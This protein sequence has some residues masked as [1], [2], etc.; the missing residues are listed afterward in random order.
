MWRLVTWSLWL[1][2]VDSIEISVAPDGSRQ[3]QFS[4][5]QREVMTSSLRPTQLLA[6]YINTDEQ[7]ERRKHMERQAR[8]ANLPLLRFPAINRER[9]NLG[10]F[11]KKY[12]L[13]Q[14][15]SSELLDPVR[16]KDHVVNATVACYV[17][18]NELLETFQR[19]LQPNQIGLVLEDDVEIPHNWAELIDN[20]LSCAPNDWALLKVSGWGYS[21]E[22]DLQDKPSETDVTNSSGLALLSWL[23]SQGGWMSRILYGAPARKGSIRRNITQRHEL[24]QIANKEFSD[25]EDREDMIRVLKKLLDHDSPGVPEP[26]SN[27]DHDGACP[28]AYLM[29][30]PFKETFWWHFWG[31]AF[32]YAGT[33]AYLVKASSIPSVLSHLRS[34]PINDID[35]MLLS[36]GDLRAYELWPHIFPLDGDH[37]KSTMLEEPR[38]YGAA[39]LLD[40]LSHIFPGDEE[41]SDERR[42]ASSSDRRLV[43]SVRASSDS[44]TK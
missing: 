29:R 40:T 28:D 23:Q 18:H 7:E 36:K 1:L 22:A 2:Q 5:L 9:V 15:L 17:S 41:G 14:N 4:L 32:H 39:G 42:T 20:A 33:G 30:T 35:G 25:R 13:K 3:I 24:L 6:Y 11:D 16:K 26:S 27:D 44:D 12:V 43:R 31:P 34:Q 19:T 38:K 8:A 21:R 10:E 37:M